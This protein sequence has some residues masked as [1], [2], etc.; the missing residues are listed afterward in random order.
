M[1]EECGPISGKVQCAYV[2]ID[3]S[4]EHVRA[5]TRT[6]DVEPMKPEDLPVWNFDGS[7][8]GQSDGK[9][10]DV[11]LKPVALFR[12][13]FR[14]GSNKLVLCETEDPYHRPTATNH[15]RSCH[16]TMSRKEVHE[17]IPWFGI[18]QEY[19]L[20]EPDLKTPLGW[21]SGGY[22]GPQGP[23][24]CGVGT[25]KVFGRDIVEAHYRA[26]LYAGIKIAG[27]NAEVMPSQ[28]E[29]QVGPCEGIDMGDQLWAARYILH[30]TAEDFGAVVSLDPKPISG[31]W[32]G[33]GAHTNYS[34]KAMREPG[35]I[36]H[37]YEA[38]E[39][40]KHRHIEHIKVY[41]PTGG[42]DNARRLTGE[43]ETADIKT[44]SSGVGDRRASVR[45]PRQVADSE[46]GYLEDRR[47]ASN[48]DPYLVTE[49]IVR[50]TMLE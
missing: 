49:R 20:F 5:K 34:T 43:H 41:D 19:T 42:H 17:A 48:C 23:Y 50:T 45:I 11:Y 32:N 37:I 4:G 8:T 35:G 21:P 9:N 12:D 29:F 28:W 36:K 7:S 33:A 24:Y 31:D 39:H 18:E 30:R 44:F 27:T 25:T 3:G 1:T 26:C 15:R 13:P 10:S 6:L 46:R 16:R 38:I 2:W 40:L 47:P 22:P 14:L